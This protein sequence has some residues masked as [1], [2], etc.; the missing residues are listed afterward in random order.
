[1]IFNSATKLVLVLVVIAIIA[2]N[3]IEIDVKEPL[4]TIAIMIVSFYFGKSQVP[5]TTESNDTLSK[6]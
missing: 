2:L 4:K 3:F 6:D 5:V 1:M